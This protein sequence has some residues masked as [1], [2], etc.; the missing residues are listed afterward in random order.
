MILRLCG[1]RNTLIRRSMSPNF[2]ADN[3]ANFYILFLFI[4]VE[5]QHGRYRTES[6]SWEQLLIEYMI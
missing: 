5:T 6:P 4:Y 2:C 1:G 3:N